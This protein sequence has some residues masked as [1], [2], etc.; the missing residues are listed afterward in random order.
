MLDTAQSLPRCYDV[1][2]HM[3]S[4][5]IVLPYANRLEFFTGTTSL[6][7]VANRIMDGTHKTIPN[8]TGGGVIVVRDKIS[9][10]VVRDS[11]VREAAERKQAECGSIPSY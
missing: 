6:Q 3:R 11:E 4:D 8:V 5:I 1:Y 2:I 10:I 7:G 9:H